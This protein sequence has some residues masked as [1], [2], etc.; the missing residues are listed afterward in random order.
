MPMRQIKTFYFIEKQEEL[1]NLLKELD[2]KFG[3]VRPKYA[4]DSSIEF[5]VLLTYCFSLSQSGALVSFKT[6]TP[7]QIN[8]LINGEQPTS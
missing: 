7:P 8:R 4:Y 1:D 2:V 6:L 3:A 5:P